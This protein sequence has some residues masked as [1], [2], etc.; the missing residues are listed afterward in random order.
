MTKILE[1]PV[2]LGTVRMK[3]V[4]ALSF[5]IVLRAIAIVDVLSNTPI[6]I[7][8]VIEDKIEIN[9]ETHIT[10]TLHSFAI[11]WKILKSRDSR[12][13]ADTHFKRYETNLS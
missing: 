11:L 10:K 2:R 13:V 4:V 12:P 6:F 9:I 3:Q 1:N 7:I 5:L 8:A